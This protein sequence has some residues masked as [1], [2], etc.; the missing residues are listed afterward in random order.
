MPSTADGYSAHL[1]QGVAAALAAWELGTYRDDGQY[2]AGEFRP[3]YFG[4]SEP[5]NSPDER[6]LLTVGTPARSASGSTRTVL[7]PVGFN[8]RGAEDGDVLE[9]VNVIDQIERRLH[10]LAHYQFGAVRVGLVLRDSAGALGQDGRRRQG[11][12]ATYTFRGRLDSV[13]TQTPTGAVG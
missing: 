11:A 6:L 1:V 12:S 5:P 3:I 9:A 10:R 7:T 2:V 8:W 13:N 4:P